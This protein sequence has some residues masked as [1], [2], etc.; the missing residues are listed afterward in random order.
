MGAKYLSYKGYQGSCEADLDEGFLYG[1]ILFINDLVTYEAKDVPQLKAE[2][3]AAVED[4]LLTCEE[5]GKEPNKAF[6]GSF[7]VRIPPEDHKKLTLIAMDRFNGKLN[8]V[9]CAAVSQF[10]YGPKAI[11]HEHFF[12]VN[13]Q[14]QY[15]GQQTFGFHAFT[16]HHHDKPYVLHV[17]GP[18]IE[19]IE[20]LVN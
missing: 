2:F 13:H 17:E 3:E 1:K 15:E 5:L 20:R 11:K 10:I 16:G 7:N 6:T 9:I 14:L 12:L 4:Y 19:P 8:Q 18:G